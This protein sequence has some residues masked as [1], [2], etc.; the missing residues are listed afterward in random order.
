MNLFPFLIRE[1][2]NLAHL[3]IA[4]FAVCYYGN[5]SKKIVVIGVTGTD[6]KTTTSNFIYQLLQLSGKKAA[7]ISTT[8]AY[9]GEKKQSLG[10]HV[11]TPSPFKLQKYLKKAVESNKE[12]IVLEVSSHALDQH[13]VFGI[14]FE[15]GILTNISSEHLD[16]HKT[17][18]NYIGEKVKLLNNAKYAVLNKDDSNFDIVLKKVKNRKIYK[19]SLKDKDSNLNLDSLNKD[20]LANFTDF[21]KSNALASVLALEILGVKREQ[22]FS[23]IK[24]LTLPLGRLEAVQEKPF[25]VIVDFAHTP[26][27]FESLLSE[28]RKTT[29]GKLIHVFGSAGKR[30]RSKRPMMGEASSKY[31]DI[32]ILTA[33]DPRNEKVFDINKE[34]LEGVDKKFERVESSKHKLTKNYVIKFEDRENAINYALNI[35]EPN[36]TVLITGKGHEESMNMGRGEISWNDIE[37]T[38]KL[39]KR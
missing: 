21:N 16:Y 28:I 1:L 38:K 11:T 18:D 8:G 10:F 20:F 7:L 39:L 29:K 30:D 2:K 19:Y 35:A 25:R 34:I 6:G 5:P 4:I 13:R 33:E 22:V 9:I 27:A 36:D 15:V 17:L 24:N 3:M 37:I 26:N 12:Y 14:S 32:I 31:S 23:K